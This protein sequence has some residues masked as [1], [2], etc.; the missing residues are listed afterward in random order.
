MC[1]EIQIPLEISPHLLPNGLSLTSKLQQG[2]VVDIIP[3][4]FNENYFV[5]EKPC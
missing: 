4:L 1:R 2:K 5:F 3:T